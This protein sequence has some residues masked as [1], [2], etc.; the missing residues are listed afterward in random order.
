M[1]STETELAKKVVLSERPVINEDQAAFEPALLDNLIQNISMVSSVLHKQAESLIPKVKVGIAKI[2]PEED[3][4][5]AKSPLSTNDN[6]QIKGDHKN[7]GEN[8]QKIDLRKEKEAPKRKIE[9]SKPNKDTETKSPSQINNLIDLL[10]NSPIT[11]AET[12]PNPVNTNLQNSGD[13]LDILETTSWPTT[14]ISQSSNN[15]ASLIDFT[16]ATQTFGVTPTILQNVASFE[17]S[18]P[19][20]YE[21]KIKMTDLYLKIGCFKRKHCRFCKEQKW[22]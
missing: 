5:K 16:S 2:V 8:K 9:I 10:D 12:K 22:S 20:P 4:E 7:N 11:K 1:L 19:V 15:S 13:L 21:V 3:N 6:A 14:Q 18:T 17:T